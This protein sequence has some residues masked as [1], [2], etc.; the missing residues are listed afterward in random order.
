MGIRLKFNLVLIITLSLGLLFSGLMSYEILQKNAEN[1]AIHNAE[2][3]MQAAQ[4]IRT[5]TV[6]Q[7]K[8]L[9]ALQNKRQFIPQT[10]PAYAATQNF[11]D[12]QKYYPEYT[13]KEAVLNPTNPIHR[14]TDWEADIVEAYR[15]DDS[16]KSL[17]GIRNSITGKQL[18]IS[19]P[20]KIKD[21]GCLSCH[22]VPSAAPETMLALYGSANGFGWKMNEVIGAQIV[23]V[24]L[25]IPLKRARQVFYTFMSSLLG[26]FVF[27]LFILN[28]ML[29]FI[30]IKPIVNMSHHAHDISMGKLDV[31]EFEIKGKDE[32]NDLAGSFNRMRRSLDNAM[33]ILSS[34]K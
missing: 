14:A 5:Y 24:P 28:L 15:N 27:I 2:I 13:Y 29:H 3:M 20:I 8:P 16:K 17:Q 7:I 10:V 34:S 1:E 23:S 19:Q 33:T 31:P 25:E 32:I 26:I 18:F 12:L 30:I 11:H 4:S 9:L 21:E 22:S 6:S